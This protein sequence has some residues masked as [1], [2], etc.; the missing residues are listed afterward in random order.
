ML[1]I[2]LNFLIFHIFIKIQYFLITDILTKQGINKMKKL[3]KSRFVVGV[4][5]ITF[6]IGINYL[7][8]KDITKERKYEP[9][10]L[11]GSV[12]FHFYDVPVDSIYLYAYCDSSQTW[13]MMP[14]Q[15]DERIRTEDP[16]HPGNENMWRHSYFIPDD[17]VL[18]ADDEIVFMTCDLGDKAPEGI[19]ID[20]EEA[21][22]HKRLE[23]KI[24]D[25]ND[26]ETK[27]YGYLF[28]SSTITIPEEVKEKYGFWF[29]AQENSVET[30]YYTVGLNKQNSVIED[31]VLKS[32]FG[33]GKDIFD[34]QKL[35]FAGVIEYGFGIPLSVTEDI[36]ST[37][38]Y[39]E[40][41]KNP[42]VRLIRETRVAMLSDLLEDMLAFYV[43]PKFYP[44]SATLKGGMGISVQA[45]K[46]AFNLDDDIWV[47][48]DTLRQS[49]DFSEEADSM[50]FYNNYNDGV[51]IDGNA[52]DVNKTIDFK[53][54][55]ELP[56]IREWMLTS[57]TQGSFF[58]YSEFLDTTWQTVEL[59][60]EDNNSINPNDTGEDQKSF[61][62]Q[63]IQFI[64]QPEDS[65][66]LELGF[67]AYF[68]PSNFTKNEAEQLAY[69]VENP[70]KWDVQAITFPT[71]VN[72][73]KNVNNL[74]SYKLFQ[75]YPNPFNSSTIINFYLPKNAKVTLKI[76]DVTGRTIV[77]LADRLLNSGSH[78]VHWDG[79]SRFNQETPSG[80][81]FY[82]LE[83]DSFSDV[84]KLILMR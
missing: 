79:K 27:A 80:V 20:N 62:D 25:P 64:S 84:K 13:N 3:M 31:I 37:S 76:L 50:R 58:T 4:L 24:Y 49:W 52:D 14:F 11:Q 72:D 35:R 42:V 7:L 78:T 34:R 17:G 22:Q 56:P 19:W 53:P 59:Y 70:V 51:L 21:K 12:L 68:L 63:G 1:A 18:D 55:P 39:L 66:N 60:F 6:S 74:R 69:F 16:F 41:T 45:F 71:G 30:N 82:V 54:H 38:S 75:N 77:T 29:H 81:Y 28:R 67:K 9:V 46:D 36:I 32:P 57:G 48:F 65:I 33:N 23:L 44:F 15:I 8:A 73:R 43:T 61:G 10:V 5:L 2:T 83:S 40:Y 26:P 47:H